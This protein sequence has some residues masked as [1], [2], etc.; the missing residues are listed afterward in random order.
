MKKRSEKLRRH[1]RWKSA[2]VMFMRRKLKPRNMRRLLRRPK[3]LQQTVVAPAHFV[4]ISPKSYQKGTDVN[5]YFKFLAEL[6][7]V[8]TTEVVVDM[9]SVR[10][11]VVDAALLFKAELSR[12]TQVRGI[13]IKGIPPISLRTQQVLKQTGIDSLLNLEFQLL[14]NREDV[15]HWRIAEGPRTGVDPSSLEPIMQDIEEV[16]GLATHPVYQ[17]IIESIGNCA[18]HAYKSHPEVTWKMPENPSWWVFQQVKDGDLMVVVC[19]LGI[20]VSR[21]LPLTLAGEQGLLRKLMHVVR[22]TKG[23][24]ARALLAA[25]EYG[26]SS[27]GL[28]ERGKGMKNAH[29]VINDHGMGEFFAMSNKGFY[30]YRKLSRTAKGE[31][32][33]FKLR[34]SINGTILGWRLPIAHAPQEGTS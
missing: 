11:M 2:H 21:A 17:G 1:Q 19:D 15:I 23:E 10:R 27:T 13:R 20:G 16:T 33:T 12:L 4:L 7:K 5:N 32:T 18:E 3:T 14:P 34:H 9:T 29:A 28:H 25:M 22:R 6:R 30:V 24:D 31:Y 26:R 8:H